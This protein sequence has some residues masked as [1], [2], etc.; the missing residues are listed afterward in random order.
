[1]CTFIATALAQTDHAAAKA[2]WRLVA[3]QMR[4]KPSKLA[5]LKDSAEEDVLACMTFPARH[6]AKVQSTTP[7]ER[8]NGEISQ[9]TGL[10]VIFLK[11]ASIRR[12]AGQS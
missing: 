8:P 7:F 3:Y 11:K 4:P 6:R 9:R 1:M 2:Q 10:V 5:T 12:L